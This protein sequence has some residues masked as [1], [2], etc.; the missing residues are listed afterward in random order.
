MVIKHGKD[1]N[2]DKMD[3]DIKEGELKK[4]VK[5]E[6]GFMKSRVILIHIRRIVKKGK[7]GLQQLKEIKAER[8]TEKSIK[9]EEELRS[10]LV[11]AIMGINEVVKL[12]IKEKGKERREIQE[13]DLIVM[14]TKELT[15][16]LEQT[17]KGVEISLR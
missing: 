13:T 11:K 7:Q 17:L 14:K 8:K 9:K 3:I 15:D 12:T 10:R 6:Y 4:Q 5:Q 2:K 16:F 1:T